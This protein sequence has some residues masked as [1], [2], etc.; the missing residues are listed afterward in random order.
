MPP[1]PMPWGVRPRGA[2]YFIS[3]FARM[4]L[5]LVTLLFDCGL[6]RHH[7]VAGA[8]VGDAEGARGVPEPFAPRMMSERGDYFISGSARM[9]LTFV[10]L[11]S[12]GRCGARGELPHRQ[13]PGHHRC[14]G[15]DHG[16]GAAC[17]GSGKP[18]KSRRA[19]RRGDSRRRAPDP[20]EDSL[21][22]GQRRGRERA[23]HEASVGSYARTA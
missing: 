7:G 4:F 1:S 18:R 6:D 12:D 11:L 2:T 9:F 17:A 22:R 10:A 19:R 5:T 14:V 21:E 8:V 13:R 15:A 16:A 3:G 20:G 23:V